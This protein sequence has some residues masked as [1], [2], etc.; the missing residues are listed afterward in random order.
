MTISL[1]LT[2]V[3]SLFVFWYVVLVPLFKTQGGSYFSDIVDDFDESV[4]A[5][6]AIRELEI[7]YKMDKLT[8]EEYEEMSTE[9]KREYLELKA[10]KD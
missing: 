5:L 10:L 2:F 4:V 1:I 9:L 3:I 8:D 7:D 6:A